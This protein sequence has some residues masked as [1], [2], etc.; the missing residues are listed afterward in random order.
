MMLLLIYHLFSAAQDALNRAPLDDNR[1]RA[2]DDIAKR[3]GIV[4][5]PYAEQC[6][7]AGKRDPSYQ[8]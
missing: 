4:N 8:S 6:H 3:L 2:A 5:C 7:Y 1:H